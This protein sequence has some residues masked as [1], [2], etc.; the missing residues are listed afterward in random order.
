V[1]A[2]FLMLLTVA[3]EACSL[4]DGLCD[5]TVLRALE[6][7][8]YMA[9]FDHLEPTAIGQL[10]PVPGPAA[11]SI[12][13]TTSTVTL[14]G[15]AGLDFGATAKAWAADEAVR[16]YGGDCLVEIGGDVAVQG[17]NG[18]GPWAIGVWARGLE[19]EPR[20]PIGLTMG[21]LATSAVTFRR[22]PTASGEAHHL[23][24]PRTGAPS[25]GPYAAVTVAAPTCVL[26]N[27]LTTAALIDG[28]DG[29]HRVAQSGWAGRFVRHDGTSEVVGSWPQEA[30]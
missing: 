8:G 19:D 1:S 27:A 11:I 5:P 25:E 13:A 22:W 6:A 20:P 9:D 3:L 7:W 2:D 10:A 12:D 15:G 21:G 29:P 4:T 24:D 26:A 23:I 30:S 18:D 17:N 16:R 28:I 14:A